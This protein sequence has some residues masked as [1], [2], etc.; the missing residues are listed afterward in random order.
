MTTTTITIRDRNEWKFLVCA[1]FKAKPVPR[2]SMT[3]D[4]EFEAT[5]ELFEARRDY[6]LNRPVR[7]LDFIK[8]STIV[9]TLIRTHRDRG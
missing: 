8:A 4:A 9:D 7:V 1:G 2:N 6:A 3:L 5:D